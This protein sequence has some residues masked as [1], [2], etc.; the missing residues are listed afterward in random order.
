MITLL[1]AALTATGTGAGAGAGT[2]TGTGTGTNQV[3]EPKCL[4]QRHAGVIWLDFKIV[5][6]HRH[7]ITLN[8]LNC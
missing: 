8:F 3:C 4:G 7:Q 5:P 2:G 6:H 1:L